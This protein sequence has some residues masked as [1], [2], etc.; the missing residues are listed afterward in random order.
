MMVFISAEIF[1]TSTI[2]KTLSKTFVVNDDPFLLS[3]HSQWDVKPEF[4]LRQGLIEREV[5]VCAA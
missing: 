1:S 2:D 3:L 4:F 5:Q